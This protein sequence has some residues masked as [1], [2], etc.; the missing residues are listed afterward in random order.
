LNDCLTA[1]PGQPNLLY[2]RAQTLSDWGRCR[3]ALVGFLAAEAR[4]F[5]GLGLEI[6]IAQ[7]C[8]LLGFADEAERRVRNALRLDPSSVVA[9]LC[10]G[11]ILQSARR[12]ED[13]IASY[14]H[15]LE[16]GPEHVECL[17]FITACWLDLKRPIEGEVAARRAIAANRQ[18]SKAWGFLGVALS[19]Q[20][21]RDEAL[22]A[23]AR[24]EDIEQRTGLPTETFVNHGNS[25]LGFCRLDQ[26]YALYERHL[27]AS[28]HPTAL[29]NYGFGLLTGGFYREGWSLYDFRWFAEPLLSVRP[30]FDKPA[31][32]GQSLA[33]KTL[34]LWAEQ[35][36]GDTVQFARYA[37][38]FKRRGARVILQVPARLR[39]F[40][41]YL[42]DVDAVIVKP[43]E[44]E[45]GFDFH[46]PTMS[47][48]R[49]FG[50][51]LDTVPADVPYLET[52]PDRAARWRDCLKPFSSLK[53]G[54]VWAGNSDHERDRYRSIALAK[55]SPLF[56]VGPVQWVSLQ[57]DARAGDDALIA[58]HGLLDVADDLKDFRDTA[59][60]IAALDLVIAVDTAVA[61]VAGALGKP[62]WVLLPAAGDFRWLIDRGDC[63]WYPS[64]RLFRQRQ[65]GEWDDVVADVATALR[66][67][68]GRH[69][70]GELL[71]AP[72]AAMSGRSEA[73]PQLP[74]IRMAGEFP[75][76]RVVETRYGIVQ[77]L[78][79][80]G[81]IA[82]ALSRYGE[83]RQHELALLHRLLPKGATLVEAGSGIGVHALDL[84]A[85]VGAAGYILA[86]ENDALQRRVLAHNLHANKLSGIVTVMQRPLSGPT[87][88]SEGA[89]SIDDLQLERLHLIKVQSHVDA[90]R[91]LDGASETLWRHRPTLLLQV[92]REEALAALVD[93]VKAFGYRCWRVVVP[94]FEPDNYNA[95][96]DDVF[97]GR[98]ELALLAVPEECDAAPDLPDS[99]LPL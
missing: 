83:W 52:D 28:P 85:H 97:G 78:P 53:V 93:R 44:L 15:A 90:A 61:H 65:L 48:P 33:G 92:D 88:Q 62:A 35:G 17:T 55:L 68:V 42:R 54:L 38:L 23:F 84:A 89:E 13:A 16:L 76:S 32:N 36:I 50:T 45:R 59:A 69:S 2:A 79:D 1:H 31:W 37:S 9:H 81:L 72:Q 7:T 30:R 14:H 43:D 66:D 63:P 58:H 19:L 82:T 8:H 34:L 20:D 98:T 51:E 21:R 49:A 3:E 4:G 95:R 99:C 11:G 47:A 40:A 91:I 86:Y 41:V 46:I 56:G 75:W 27:R 70:R 22:D 96:D 6:N 39:E 71:E 73:P 25:L 5:A 77:Y 60:A 94:L 64:M 24:A 80:Q 10:L 87:A 26:A 74:P 57:K 67:A 12:Y 29:A 18:N